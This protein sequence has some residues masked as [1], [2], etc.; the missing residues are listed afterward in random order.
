M[1]YITEEFLVLLLAYNERIIQQI[2][3]QN[4]QDLNNSI[5]RFTLKLKEALEKCLYEGIT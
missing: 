4:Y 5:D 1:A 3:F 2:G